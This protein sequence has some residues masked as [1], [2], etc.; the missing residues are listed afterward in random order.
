[1]CQD[2]VLSAFFYNL[3]APG[4]REVALFG[5]LVALFGN[6]VAGFEDLVAV[7]EREV[8]GFGKKVAPGD[9][10]VQLF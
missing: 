5:N 3:V 2:S 1:L 8:A 9:W 6:L 4:D 10:G 7:F